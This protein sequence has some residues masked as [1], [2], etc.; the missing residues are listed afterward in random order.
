MTKVKQF[1]DLNGTT[2]YYKGLVLHRE[3]GPAII[4]TNGSSAWFF[5]GKRHRID[6]PAVEWPDGYKAWYINDKLHR[7]DGPA[8]IKRNGACYWYLNDE[9]LDIHRY[10]N[11]VKVDVRT[12]V[13]LRNNYQHLPALLK[14]MIDYLNIKD[15]HES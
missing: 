2:K 3:D 9:E 5:E 10:V 4:R 13:F 11:S 8:L 15:V 14:S 6:G 1:T 7:E 12:D